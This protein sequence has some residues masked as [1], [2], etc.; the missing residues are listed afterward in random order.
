MNKTSHPISLLLTSSAMAA[1]AGTFLGTGALDAVIQFACCPKVDVNACAS[2]DGMH[3]RSAWFSVVFTPTL[4]VPWGR[5]AAGGTHTDSAV[6]VHCDAGGNA[7][8]CDGCLLNG[9]PNRPGNVSD[10]RRSAKL[11]FSCRA[12]FWDQDGRQGQQRT[13]QK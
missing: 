13:L 2:S 5:G 7:V 9:D 3:Y 4:R 12:N 10:G 8:L 6:G 1:A 11:P